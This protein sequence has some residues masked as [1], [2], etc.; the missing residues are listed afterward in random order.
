MSLLACA[1]D[2]F[3][4]DLN[5]QGW[6]RLLVRELTRLPQQSFFTKL[7]MP[8]HTATQS[9]SRLMGGTFVVERDDI[10]VCNV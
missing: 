6:A 8:L 7:V 2:I 1:D 9:L 10:D 3:L 4:E 5:M